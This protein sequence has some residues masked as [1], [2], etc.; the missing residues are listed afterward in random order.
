M[1]GMYVTHTDVNGEHVVY[2][3]EDGIQIL[4]NLKSKVKMNLQLLSEKRQRNAAVENQG[5]D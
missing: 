2:S 3:M 4:D 5:L 1:K